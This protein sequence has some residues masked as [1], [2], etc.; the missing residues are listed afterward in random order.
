MPRLI[1][2]F[3]TGFKICQCFL[4]KYVMLDK[5]TEFFYKF[6]TLIV[7]IALVVLIGVLSFLGYK[8]YRW[9]YP[10]EIKTIENVGVK[11]SIKIDKNKSATQVLPDA[12]HLD[13][14]IDEI[15]ST[16]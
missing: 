6:R 5:I 15:L 4:K 16:M 12:K 11:N 8:L 13:T 1:A 3:T 7:S 10:K 9:I 2:N 14:T